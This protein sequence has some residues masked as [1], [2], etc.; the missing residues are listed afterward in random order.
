MIK[1]KLISIPKDLEKEAI[2]LFSFLKSQGIELNVFMINSSI[3]Q[4]KE[5]DYKDVFN[6]WMERR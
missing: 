5:G 4:I 3:K 2:L 1:P 6:I